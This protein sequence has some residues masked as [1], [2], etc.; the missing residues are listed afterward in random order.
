MAGRFGPDWTVAEHKCKGPIRR[1]PSRTPNGKLVLLGHHHDVQLTGLRRRQHHPERL[2]HVQL[3][4]P[5]RLG[6]TGGDYSVAVRGDRFIIGESKK[7]RSF[8]ELHQLLQEGR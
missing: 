6:L 7:I 8:D 4:A 1:K 3:A 5:A 2:Q